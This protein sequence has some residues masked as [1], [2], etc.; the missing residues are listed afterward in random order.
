M[1][2]TYFF[3]V[4]SFL[5]LA[6]IRKLMVTLYF[7]AR[8]EV[9]PFPEHCGGQLAARVLGFRFNLRYSR[10]YGVTARSNHAL[11]VTG[12]PFM[13]VL[14]QSHHYFILRMKNK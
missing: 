3:F 11:T 13:M 10:F 8:R 4:I 9:E 2:E 14:S 7:R 6:Y 5:F 1:L 12:G